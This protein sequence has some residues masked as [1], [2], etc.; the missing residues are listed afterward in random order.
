[1]LYSYTCNSNTKRNPELSYYNF[2]MIKSSEGCGCIG[3]EEQISNQKTDHR[4]CSKHFIGGKKT[5]LHNTP[6]LVEKLLLPTQAK[7][8]YKCRNRNST[9]VESQQIDEPVP[10]DN[11]LEQIV[12]DLKEANEKQQSDIA[13]LNKKVEECSFSVQQFK[14]N[15]SDFE[16]YTGFCVY[17]TFQALY[18]YLCPACERLQYIGSGNSCNSVNS[19]EKCG[20]KR[21]LSPEEEIF[22]CLVRL[23]LGLL[24]REIAHRFN[25]SV[26]QVSRIWITWLDFLYRRLRS[27]PIWP[28]QEFVRA[29]MPQSSKNTYPHTRVII[30]C[31]ELFIETPSQPKTQSATFS[32]YKNHNTGKGLIGI[33]PR[34]DLTFVSEMYAG[35]TSDKKPQQACRQVFFDH[36]PPNVF[37]IF[38]MKIQA[39]ILSF[40]SNHLPLLLYF[41]LPPLM[42]LAHYPWLNLLKNLNY[43]SYQFEKYY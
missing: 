39:H 12:E 7:P 22:L 23:R 32:T 15:D 14:S 40:L 36:L 8:R 43:L 9:I 24:E 33:S 28:S 38:D 41:Y 29:T 31:T 11:D 2:Q 3:L 6:T 5:C 19:K 10:E 30:D 4:V 21:L 18:N 17:G 1:M 26:S 42:Y 34:G 13:L 37:L 35:N 16:F 25:I 27:I 20:P